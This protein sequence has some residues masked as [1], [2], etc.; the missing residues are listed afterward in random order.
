MV[1]ITYDTPELQQPFIEAAGLEFPLLSDIDAESFINL[2]ILNDE[3]EPGEGAY[4]IPFPGVFVVNADLEIVGK[5][6]V[7][8]YRTRVDAE[9]TLA[10]AIEVLNTP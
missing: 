9:T 1:A 4:G 7:E 8:G 5:V 3:Y 6:F 2:G 10:Y